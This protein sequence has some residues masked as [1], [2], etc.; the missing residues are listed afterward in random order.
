ME[1]FYRELDE[2][3]LAIAESETP[4]I[5]RWL[6]SHGSHDKAVYDYAHLKLSGHLREYSQTYNKY[7][8]I[9]KRIL[10]QV[11]AKDKRLRCSHEGLINT[12]YRLSGSLVDI[13]SDL[14][15]VL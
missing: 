4:F 8:K 15:K 11:R 10:R 5:R 7:D 14:L 9:R 1:Y 6:S 12:R 13:N 3:K 2:L